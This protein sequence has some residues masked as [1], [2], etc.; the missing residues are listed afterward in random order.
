[1]WTIW[2][3]FHCLMR[4]EEP[5]ELLCVALRNV[6]DGEQRKRAIRW[7]LALGA[8]GEDEVAREHAAD[9]VPDNRP[10][11]DLHDEASAPFWANGL[12]E[13][14]AKGGSWEGA[15]D[16][17]EHDDEEDAPEKVPLALTLFGEDAVLE[18]NGWGMPASRS[19]PQ[20]A[21][22]SWG[23]GKDARTATRT[24]SMTPSVPAHGPEDGARGVPQAWRYS[25]IS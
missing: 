21:S 17:P 15:N 16:A 8:V 10:A 3:N 2:V 23:S 25:E 19:A 11:G 1:M 9:E 18:V 12:R 22:A 13:Q 20:A 5:L 4:S 6:S 24:G 7:H 14:E